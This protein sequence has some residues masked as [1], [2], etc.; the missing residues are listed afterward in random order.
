MK[1]N[2]ASLEAIWD[3]RME[4]FPNKGSLQEKITFLLR[5]AVLA[6]STHNSQPWLFEIR[7]AS[8]RVF[9]D[10]ARR[11]PEADPTGR[12]LFISMGC[13]LENFLLAAK[14]FGIF[15]DVVYHKGEDNLVAE[16]FFSETSAASDASLEILLDAMTRR[17]NVRGKFAERRIPAEILSELSRL[18]YDDAVRAVFVEEREKIRALAMLTAEGLRMA[19]GR[20]NFRGEI[21][22]WVHHNFSGSRDGILGHSL[23]M[24]TPVSFLLPFLM[25]FF[26]IGGVLARLNF[27]SVA[28]APLVCVFFSQ[29]DSQK[30]WLAVGQFAERLMLEF[31]AR[32]VKSS[33]FVAAIE[34]G[35]L[36]E[37]I[38]EILKTSWIPQFL[39]CAGFMD[40]SLPLTPRYPVEEKLI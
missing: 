28:S 23:R 34:M 18:K 40:V 21:S 14:Y 32:N 26:N 9:F 27:L 3:V 15:R 37:K 1:A 20:A 7:E 19:Y 12:D 6:P 35:N 8:C 25:R 24:P 36:H 10:P 31:E 2:T 13:C 39:F 11:L 17:R 16:I 30:T 33:I 5:Y 29:E 38:Q 4:H 22:R